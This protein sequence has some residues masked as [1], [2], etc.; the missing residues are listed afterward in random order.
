VSDKPTI[1]EP[2]FSDA[3]LS[4]LELTLKNHDLRLRPGQT[5][6][7]VATAFKAN[8]VQLNESNGYLNAEM[9]GQ[10][11]HLNTVTESLATKEP[12]RFFPRDVSTVKSKAE[13]DTK[14]KVQFIREHGEAAFT[15]L[16]A[17]APTEPTVLDKHRITAPEYKALS[18]KTKTEL[19]HHWTPNDIATILQRK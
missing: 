16:P 8:Q 11:V 9:H 1:V 3:L 5:L 10:P 14:A 17:A 12:E 4:A 2:D 7:D 13:M 19:L 6:Q 15:A 18:R